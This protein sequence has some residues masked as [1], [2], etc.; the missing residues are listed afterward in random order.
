M[1]NALAGIAQASAAGDAAQ[2]CFHCGL[3]VPAGT[4]F[5]ASILGRWREMCCAGCEAVAGAI[6][7]AGCESFY[8]TRDRPPPG[9]VRPVQMPQTGLYDDPLAQ[10]QFVAASGEHGRETVLLLERMRCA[11][12]TWLIEHGLRR[13]PGVTGVSI[14]F[15]T[16]RAQIAW[17]ARAVRLGD[18]IAAV[19]KLGYDAYPYDP[20]R[21]RL[22]D[23][24]SKRAALWRLFVAGFGAMQVMMYAVPGYVDDSGSLSAEA[25]QIMRWASLAL[26]LPVLVFACGPF[27]R[28]ALADLR[29]LRLGIDVPVSLG[30]LVA[31]AASAW[32]TLRGGGEVYFDSITM[33]VF[34]LLAARYVESATRVRVAAGLDRLA[35]WMPEFAL[36]LRADGGEERVPAHALGPGDRASVAPGETIPA[37]GV[38]ENGSSCVDESLLTGE[39]HPSPKNCADLLIGGSVNVDQ[40]LVMRVTHAGAQTRA[41][42]IS[43]LIERAAAGKPRLVEAA[44]R[45]A[46]WLTLIVIAAAAA[47]F[48][49]WSAID[50]QQAL[51]AAVAVLVVTCPCALGLAAPIALTSATGALARRGVVVAGA[52]AIESLA[53]ITDFV[54]DKTGTL[55]EGRLRL[56]H[57]DRLG[58]RS[59]AEC[60]AI[61]RALESGSRHPVAQALLA[62]NS[63][64]PPVQETGGLRHFPG[65]GVEA[66]IGGKHTRLG[67]MQFVQAVAGVPSVALSAAGEWS[68]VYLGDE[69]GWLG[70]FHFEDGLRPDAVQLV[71]ALKQQGLQIHLLS[72]DADAA[73]VTCAARLGLDTYRGGVSPQGKHAYVEALQRKGRRVAML[74]DGL[75]DAPVLAL[76]DVSIAMSEGAA[77][78]QRQADLVLLGNRLD[79]VPQAM[80]IAGR[81]MRVIRQNFG[82]ALAYNALALPMAAFGLI[83]PWEAAIGMAASSFVVV[84][85]SA[86]LA[87]EIR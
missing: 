57:F 30:I 8:E 2:V 81:T 32:A 19:R 42:A 55:T 49:V 50:G 75:N 87:Q 3:P 86:R 69:A 53:A 83:G 34:L 11:A 80:R 47:T 84:L 10:A 6:V 17:D 20:A 21:Q 77:L 65:L 25:E 14:N 37:D 40:P 15:A 45:I 12:C 1:F 24:A 46:Q 76:A 29:R 9:A 51:W 54:L 61:A 78:A 26:T 48:L 63:S 4:V 31:F 79:A 38:V 18:L 33:L 52:Q 5:R 67:S 41:A 72:G 74:G 60:L 7:A 13:V 85:N 59:F 70:C 23:G 71:A 28:A 43:R 73:V 64:A 35:R 66:M 62:A 56:A 68:A 22:L 44:D 16:R 36:R 82:W 39:S 58:G 27:F